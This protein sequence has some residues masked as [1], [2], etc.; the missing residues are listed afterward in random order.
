M[1]LFDNLSF[2]NFANQQEV[3]LDLA[4]KKITIRIDKRNARKC[5][6][7]IEGWDLTLDELKNHLKKMKTSYGCNGTVKEND[8]KIIFQLSGDKRDE[9]TKYLI[10]NGIEKKNINIIG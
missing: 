4:D 3:S 5:I 8:D 1:D 6:S 10:S 9:I 2:D 7:Y